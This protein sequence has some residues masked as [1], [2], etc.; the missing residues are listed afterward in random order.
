MLDPAWR[1]TTNL[2]LYARAGAGGSIKLYERTAADLARNHDVFRRSR[3][4]CRYLEHLVARCLWG[5]SCH[6]RAQQRRISSAAMVFPDSCPKRFGG[7]SARFTCR[8]RSRWRVARSAFSPLM[9][10]PDSRHVYDAVRPRSIAV[11]VERVKE[12]EEATP[13]PRLAGHKTR[14]FQR[15][16]MT[17]NIQGFHVHAGAGHDVGRGNDRDAVLQRRCARRDLGGLHQ[18]WP[19][20]VSVGLA[21]AAR[22]RLKFRRS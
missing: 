10:D 5:N 19:D 1:C 13:R 20:A 18:R 17:H 11:P 7:M 8:W 22:G 16:L 14:L 15:L 4:R 6:A 21:D 9:F 3:R 12:R 2:T